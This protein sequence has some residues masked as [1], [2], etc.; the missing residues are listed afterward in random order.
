M[1]IDLID[2]YINWH[3]LFDEQ[4]PVFCC[5]MVGFLITIMMIFQRGDDGYEEQRNTI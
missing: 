1:M 2:V 5:E 4:M 3:C